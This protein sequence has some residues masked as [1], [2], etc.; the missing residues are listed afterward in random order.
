MSK[1]WIYRTNV[2]EVNVRQYTEE[3]TF[4]AFAGHLLRLRDMGVETLWFMPITPIA[5][6]NKKGSLGSPY[7][8]SDYV[9]VNP[10]LGTLSDFKQL[11]QQA[12][13]MGFKV[14]IDWVANHTGWDHVWTKE[15][16]DYY[17]KDEDTGDFKIA[18]GMDDIIE[19]DFDNGAMRQAMIDAMKYW[20][21]ECSIDG[22]R[23]DLAFWVPLHFWKEAKAFLD[24]IK[25]L[26]WLG[27]MDPLDHPDYMDVFDA[28]YTW[29]W[30]HQ[31]E[32]FYKEQLPVGHLKGILDRYYSAPGI[33]AWFTSNHD[34]N[35]WN[36]TEYE[37]YGDAAKT[38]AIFSCLWKG[39]PLIYSGQELPNHKRLAFFEKDPINW[40]GEEQLHQFYQTLLSLKSTNPSLDARA[41]LQLLHTTNNDPLIAFIRRDQQNETIAILNFTAHEQCFRIEGNGLEG[42]YRNLFT[43]EF[44]PLQEHDI[45]LSP[46]GYLVLVKEVS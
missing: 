26:F 38:L 1:E 25:E 36:G 39:V 4:N 14:I 29:T 46:W 11:V 17:E 7:A 2:Y 32:K 8:C 33:P 19:L 23:C 21:E 24:P 13:D 5:Q 35:T 40:Q 15:H 12:H 27:E 37:K 45:Y 16:P 28:A 6:K 41:S 30:M 42:N 18:S 34:E 3:G 44:L 22:F 10:E 9:S 31:T 43:G 20:V